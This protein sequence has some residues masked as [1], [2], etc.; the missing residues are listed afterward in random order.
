MVWPR[1]GSSMV[2]MFI[3]RFRWTKL[4]IEPDGRPPKNE[5]PERDWSHFYQDNLLA[6]SHWMWIWEIQCARLF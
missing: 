4:L 2:E 6:M 1:L 5:A 3:F